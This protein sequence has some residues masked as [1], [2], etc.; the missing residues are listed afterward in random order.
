MTPTFVEYDRFLQI[1]NSSSIGRKTKRD[2]VQ[3]Y[4]HLVLE[5]PFSDVPFTARSQQQLK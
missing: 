5:T 4:L 1:E 3:R 2:Q